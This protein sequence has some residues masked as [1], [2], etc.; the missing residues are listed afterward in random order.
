MT[1]YRR[2][3][4]Q[5]FNSLDCEIARETAFNERDAADKLCHMIAGHELEA[6]DYFRVTDL[7][8]TGDFNS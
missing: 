1:Q 6:G 2:L 7:G 5:W 4:V 3:G 8:A